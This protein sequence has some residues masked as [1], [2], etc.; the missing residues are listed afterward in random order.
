MWGRRSVSVLMVIILLSIGSFV[1][2]DNTRA[3]SE[4]PTQSNKNAPLVEQYLVEGKLQAGEAA[5]VSELKRHTKDDQLRFGL[6]T[7]Q[8]LRAVEQLGQDLNRYGVRPS[9]ATD[10]NFIPIVRLPVPNN[11]EPEV[12]TYEKSRKMVQTFLE[13][14]TKAE[15]TLA[16]V[17]DANVKLPLHFGMIRLDLNGDGQV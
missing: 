6:G 15:A 16:G 9:V 14:L 13:N 7:L 8:F 11:P 10:L 17:T 5:L 3:E 4:R 2:P 1:M 12:I